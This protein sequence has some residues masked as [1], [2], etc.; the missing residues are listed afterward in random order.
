IPSTNLIGFQTTDINP[1]LHDKEIVTVLGWKDTLENRPHNESLSGDLRTYWLQW[2]RLR[3]HSGMKIDRM[4]I[5]YDRNVKLMNYNIGDKVLLLN[6]EKKKGKNPK[7][8]KSWKGPYEVLTKITELTYLKKKLIV[9]I[10]RIKKC[11][12]LAVQQEEISL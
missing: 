10:N 9:N 4:K 2:D 11:F 1:Q 8:S 7:L 3:K 6:S 5:N 12:M